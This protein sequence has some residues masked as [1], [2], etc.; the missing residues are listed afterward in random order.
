MSKQNKG[1]LLDG[2]VKYCK[3]EDQDLQKLSQWMFLHP[4]SFQLGNIKVTQKISNGHK[5]YYLGDCWPT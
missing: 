4:Q 5:K 2:L 1:T 3:V